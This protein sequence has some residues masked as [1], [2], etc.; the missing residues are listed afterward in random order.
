MAK[1]NQGKV[2]EEQ[3]KK[4]VPD[5]VLLY[6][7]PDSAQSFGHTDYLRFSAK[8][9]FDYL[10][11]DSKKHILYALELKSMDGKSI[12]FDRSPSDKGGKIHYHQILGLNNWS[13]YD[14]II[15]GFLIEFRQIETT[16][17]LEI[18]EFNRLIGIIPKKSFNFDDLEK[19]G[20]DYTIVEQQK[21]RTRYTYNIEK[22]LESTHT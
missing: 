20:I 12:S 4:S 6:R 3:I 13:K 1:N 14:G 15:C 19:C 2:F 11:W 9:P 22:L 7:I 21:A 17:F 8:N 10:L 18:S 16:I 5:Y